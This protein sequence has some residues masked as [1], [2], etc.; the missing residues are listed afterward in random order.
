MKKKGRTIL[1][2]NFKIVRLLG[3][4]RNLRL[5]IFRML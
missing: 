2:F 1:K 3:Y 4:K 5:Y